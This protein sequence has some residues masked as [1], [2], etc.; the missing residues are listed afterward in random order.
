MKNSLVFTHTTKK[1]GIRVG[2]GM[3]GWVWLV[4]K[5]GRQIC[6]PDLLDKRTECL[7]EI[8]VETNVKSHIVVRTN[9]EIFLCIFQVST[10]YSILQNYTITSRLKI[11]YYTI[12][13]SITQY[14][15]GIISKPR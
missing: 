2:L 13:G 10:N 12:V 15:Y 7:I 5:T 11:L 14:N 9:T 6:L 4:I 1:G 3:M 8:L